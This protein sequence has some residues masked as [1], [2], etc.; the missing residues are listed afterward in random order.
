[1][2]EM[3][4]LQLSENEYAE[5]LNFKNNKTKKADYLKNYHSTEAGKAK[6]KIAQQKYRAK[7]KKKKQQLKLNSKKQQLLEELKQLEEQLNN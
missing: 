4:T 3:I 6:R 2:T 1:M 5:Y 7:L